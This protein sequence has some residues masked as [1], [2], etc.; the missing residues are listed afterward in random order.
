MRGDQRALMARARKSSRL[1]EM[2]FRPT[3]WS[4]AGRSFVGFI[5]LVSEFIV[6]LQIVRDDI[7]RFEFR[8]P[9][10]IH[11]DRSGVL[12]GTLSSAQDER[13]RRSAWRAALE[14]FVDGAAQLCSPVGIQEFEE[15]R[16]LTTRLRP[17]SEEHTSELQSRVDL[18]CRLLLEKKKK[19][20][21]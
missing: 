7:E 5:V 21:K 19:K 2:V 15:L 10:E 11:R 6:G 16:G 17:R 1:A 20:R 18:V 3:C 12:P 4:C 8:V 13:H 14:G 9:A